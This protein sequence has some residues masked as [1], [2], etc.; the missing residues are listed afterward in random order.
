MRY[1]KKNP[2][3]ATAAPATPIHPVVRQPDTLGAEGVAG[4][5]GA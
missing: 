2:S 5:A 4:R 1:G 3:K